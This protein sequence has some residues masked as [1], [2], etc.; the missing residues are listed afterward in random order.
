VTLGEYYAKWI[1]L[2]SRRTGQPRRPTTIARTMAAWNKHIRPAF[3]D[4]PISSIT[5]ADVEEWHA[6]LSGDRNKSMRVLRSILASAVR[7]K[8]ITTNPAA[9][10]DIRA[11]DRIRPV[12]REDVFTDEE[13][14]RLLEAIDDRYRLAVELLGYGLR[15]GEVF[16][17]K[18]DRVNLKGDVRVD[19]QITEA[20]T[21]VEGPPKTHNGIRTLPLGTL[22]GF[23]DRLQ[24]HIGLYSQAG[25]EGY[26]FTGPDGRAPVWPSNFR[27]RVFF[28]AL[29][30]ADLRRITPHV[31]RHRA[32]SMLV[33]QGFTV[34]PG[35]H[36]LGATP[37][38]IG[39]VYAHLFDSSNQKIAE[40]LAARLA[41]RVVR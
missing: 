35:A 14:D 39:R 24:R 10:A 4:R 1:T 9:D 13:M 32:A 5:V 16:G 30:R 12:Q 33:E 17:L 11:Q 37:A 18:R 7:S 15:I 27:D 40:G 31:L 22:P 19:W 25:P 34:E 20:G 38:T 41:S 26:V 23:A 29:E 6:A 8:I 28:P 2:P 21:L 3:G 36:G